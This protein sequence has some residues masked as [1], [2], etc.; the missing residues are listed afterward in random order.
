MT[1]VMSKRDD[2]TKNMQEQLNLWTARLDAL[3]S[4]VDPKVQIEHHKQILEWRAAG[5]LAAAKLTELKATTG[6]KWDVVKLEMQKLWTFIAAALDTAESAKRAS[7]DSA[8]AAIPVAVAAAPAEK[9]T[10]L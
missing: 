2:F 6:D 9:P 3:T 8:R 7:D 1:V 5:E 10:A 4:K